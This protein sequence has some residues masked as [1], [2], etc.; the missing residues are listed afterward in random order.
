MSLN[1]SPSPTD[2]HDRRDTSGFSPP[3]RPYA[4]RRLRRP[5][6]RHVVSA[7]APTRSHQASPA[8]E[9]ASESE[10]PLGLFRPD[11]WLDRRPRRRAW[12][13]RLADKAYQGASPAI[14]VPFRGRNP[15]C[16][17]RRHTRDHAKI[18][19]LGERAM[20]TLKNWRLLRQFRCGTTRI[21]AIV[22][23]VVAL[24]PANRSGRATLSAGRPPPDFRSWPERCV[25]G[26]SSWLAVVRG[27]RASGGACRRFA[28][29]FRGRQREGCP[30]ASAPEGF[31]VECGRIGQSRRP[32]HGFREP[33]RHRGLGRHG[34]A[35]GLRPGRGLMPE[36]G[37]NG[38]GR[39]PPAAS[40]MTRPAAS[41]W[42]Y[43]T[44]TSAGSG[45]WRAGCGRRRG[46]G[47]R[48]GRGGRSPS[49]RRSG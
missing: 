31:A 28:G 23:A 10:E 34:G 20:A 24:E 49:V 3:S 12:R 35:A 30:A 27:P 11:G 41:R 26:N 33:Q 1:L 17:C 37:Q 22:R 29:G 46:R 25:P 14:R 19:S 45:W 47:R 43:L 38:S 40:C 2:P 15:R 32:G 16:W 39:A 8:D 21:T 13:K 7:G 5:E 36:A 44:C 42:L 9:C 6:V 18:R 4:S 48:N